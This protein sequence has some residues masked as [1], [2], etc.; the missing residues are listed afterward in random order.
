MDRKNLKQIETGVW[1]DR[2]SK[3]LLS[4]TKVEMN[5]KFE[6]VRRVWPAGKEALK[7]ARLWRETVKTQYKVKH[8]TMS[9]RTNGTWL[10][11]LRDTTKYQSQ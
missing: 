3:E 1:R 8:S 7:A 11:R 5:G 10:V 9:L 4:V 6:K 2:S